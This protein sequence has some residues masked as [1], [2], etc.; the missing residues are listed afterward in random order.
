MR[1]FFVLFAFLLEK[2]R[3]AQNSSVPGQSWRKAEAC[4]DPDLLKTLTF[5]EQRTDD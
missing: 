2:E 5:R 1:D 3:N 4:L